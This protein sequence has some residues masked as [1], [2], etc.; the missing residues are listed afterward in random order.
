MMELIDVGKCI[1]AAQQEQGLSNAEFARLAETSPQQVIRWRRNQN[2]KLHTM[3]ALAS[4]L[5]VTLIDLIS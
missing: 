5:G 4:V 2:M 1:R 3:Q